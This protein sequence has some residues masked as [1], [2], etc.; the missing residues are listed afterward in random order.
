MPVATALP[1]S[2]SA[3][4]SGL[5]DAVLP[6]LRE[7]VERADTPRGTTPLAQT[8]PMQR[9][10]VELQGPAAIRP[11]AVAALAR[12]GHPVLAVTATDREASELTTE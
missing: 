11:L 5:L 4:L 3:H 9:A 10:T 7:L 8:P 6:A 12:A 2:T 1:T